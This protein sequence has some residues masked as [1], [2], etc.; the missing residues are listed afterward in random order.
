MWEGLIMKN[1]KKVKVALALFFTLSLLIETTHRYHIRA[2]L[3]FN[4]SWTEI[5][6]FI[7]IGLILINLK[8]IKIIVTGVLLLLIYIATKS[9]FF[10]DLY[11]IP[12]TLLLRDV[13][14]K[15]NLEVRIAYFFH[16]TVYFIFIYLMLKRENKLERAIELADKKIK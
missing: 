5:L 11:R 14:N 2:E 3:D 10:D 1:N 12:K 13:C 6:L 8:G 16:L 9:V 4:F 15:I 7:L